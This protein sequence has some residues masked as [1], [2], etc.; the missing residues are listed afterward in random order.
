MSL[1]LINGLKKDTAFKSKTEEKEK[2]EIAKAA[3]VLTGNLYAL[4]MNIYKGG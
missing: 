1:A 2:A 3:S 4:K